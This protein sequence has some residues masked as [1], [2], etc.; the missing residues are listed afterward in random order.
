[1]TELDLE[2]D[3]P[4]KHRKGSQQRLCGID[5][6][7]E[8]NWLDV[9]RDQRTQFRN[10]K[11]LATF[12]QK[13]CPPDK[14]PA[15]LLTVRDGLRQ[16]FRDT[17]KFM[18]FVV[19]LPEYRATAGDAA[20]S[21]LADHLGVDI[22]AVDQLQELAASADPAA[23][24][25]FIESHIDIEHVTAWAS[26]NEARLQALR[27][28]AGRA[29]GPP[30][31][32]AETIAAL[33]VVSGLTDDDVRFVAEFFGASSDRE[34]RIELLRAVTADPS[35]RYVTGEVL[36]ERTPQRI[37]DARDAMGAY[38]ALL[39]DEASTETSMQ[40]FI[41][42]NL[43]LLGLDYAVMRPRKSGPSGATDFLLQRYDG[44][45]DLLELK[46]PH[47]ELIQAPDVSEGEAVPS[48]HEYALSKTLAQALAQAIVY[49]DRLTRYAD[50]AEELYGLPHTREPRLIIVIGKADP[51]PNHRRR[52]LH[53]LN[54]SLHRVEVVPYDVLAKRA[55]AV[56]DNV[57]H[58]LLAAEETS[59]ARTGDDDG[60]P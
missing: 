30:A 21:Y 6:F 29:D 26:D 56:L 28:V 51:L 47:D 12:V 13:K 5:V 46:S 33:D 23:L 41:E 1:L 15:L 42:K 44:F 50:A 57:D 39:D 2:W 35:G 20:L 48:P 37:Q 45:H 40:K 55:T 32:L 11:S 31:S 58:Y 8:F 14:T 9:F 59:S 7:H 4:L 43:W 60:P 54:K 36:A 22:T 19:N 10:G 3:V 49:R 18:V 16:G 24:R 34:Q 25:T 38:Q 53:E 17:P 52:V 27:E